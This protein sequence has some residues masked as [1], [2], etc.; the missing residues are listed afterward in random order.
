MQV[1][2]LECRLTLSIV[3]SQLRF[4]LTTRAVCGTFHIITEACHGMPLICFLMRMKDAS[5][6]LRVAPFVWC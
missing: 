4:G 3:H 6:L 2:V 1:L 5:Y